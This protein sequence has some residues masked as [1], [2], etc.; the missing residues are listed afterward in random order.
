MYSYF[1]GFF[2]WILCTIVFTV[3]FLVIYGLKLFSENRLK[4]RFSEYSD[5]PTLCFFGAN[6]CG[7]C[8]KFKPEWEKLQKENTTSVVLVRL[9]Q[10][11]KKHKDLFEKHDV[12]GFPTLKYCPNGLNHSE[13]CVPYNGARE[14]GPIL[15][16]L[17]NQ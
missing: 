10:T 1:K 14:A 4:E 9:E 17:K 3:L 7:Y 15:E 5:K 2:N 11:E 16:F 13:S 8:K 6:W 12:K